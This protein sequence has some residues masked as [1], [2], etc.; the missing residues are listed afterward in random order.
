MLHQIVI[1]AIGTL[2]GIATFLAGWLFAWLRNRDYI[3]RWTVGR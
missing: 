1:S 3:W 2:L